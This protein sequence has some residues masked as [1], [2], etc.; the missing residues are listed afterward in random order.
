[1]QLLKSIKQFLEQKYVQWKLKKTFKNNEMS[2]FTLPCLWRPVLYKLDA[3]LGLNWL[4]YFVLLTL[5][6]ESFAPDVTK[7][8]VLWYFFATLISHHR[9]SDLTKP[10]LKLPDFRGVCKI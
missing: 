6:C 5:F 10:N 2:I 3:S 7:K 1:M 4:N 8:I 9:S